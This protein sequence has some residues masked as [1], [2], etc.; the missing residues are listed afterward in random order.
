MLESRRQALPAQVSATSLLP[1]AFV[2]ELEP[3]LVQSQI[4]I[5][6]NLRVLIDQKVLAAV[7]YDQDASFI[8]TR[9]LNINPEFEEL[10]FDLGPD[11]HANEKLR[12]SEGLT[13]VAF[14]D[15]IKV[16]FSVKRAELTQFEN[17]PAFRVRA[18]RSILRLQ[19]RTAFRA[20][21]QISP[22]PY[23]LLSQTPDKFGKSDT[24]RIKIADISANGFAV[25]TPLGRPILTAGMQLPSCLFEL[26]PTVS[27]D[28]D[29]EVRHV[30]IS[31]DGFGRET[32]RA[33]CQLLNTSSTTEMVIQRYVN[34]IGVSKL[35]RR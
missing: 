9:F 17:T 35:N 12:A 18:P 23:I 14:V 19:R 6:A 5:L 1:E 22:S 24:A 16:Q 25:V 27:F 13:V 10:I 21:T 26:E 33:G 20:R 32:C 31:K 11:H 15:H 3:F 34:R 2:R 8:L 28:V 4:E 7:Y 29:I 30:A